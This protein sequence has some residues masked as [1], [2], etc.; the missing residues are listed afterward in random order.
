MA[1]VNDL[2]LLE[3]DPLREYA[4]GSDKSM[5]RLKW[6]RVFITCFHCVDITAQVTAL[7]LTIV[8]LSIEAFKLGRLC[9]A[10]IDDGELCCCASGIESFTTCNSNSVPSSYRLI[11]S[12]SHQVGPRTDRAFT[13]PSASFPGNCN[14]TNQAGPA[15]SMEDATNAVGACQGLATTQFVLELFGAVGNFLQLL[16]S[17]CMVCV[18]MF[19]QVTKRYWMVPSWDT[20]SHLWSSL[21]ILSFLSGLASVIVGAVFQDCMATNGCN[22]FTGPNAGNCNPISDFDTGFW[23]EVAAVVVDGAALLINAPIICIVSAMWYREVNIRWNRRANQNW[24]GKRTSLMSRLV[25]LILRRGDTN[26]VGMV[27][28]ATQMPQTT[29]LVPFVP[30]PP[31]FPP[32]ALP[33]PGITSAAPTTPMAPSPV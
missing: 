32:Y 22:G 6:T 15:Q 27:G 9:N 20:V 19:Q 17:C 31:P 25:L 26:D 3:S 2:G 1:S 12:L 16:T 10:T 8:S 13:S 30:T 23:L 33:P 29:A 14:A 28:P 7:V 5:R 18:I 11:E 4:L 24:G 21:A